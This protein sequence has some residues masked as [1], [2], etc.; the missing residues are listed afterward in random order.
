MDLRGKNDWTNQNLIVRIPV[1]PVMGKDGKEIKGKFLEIQADHSNYN[2]KTVAKGTNKVKEGALPPQR[3]PYLNSKKVAGKDGNTFLS[4]DALYTLPQV[5]KIVAAAGDAHFRTKS[6]TTG[7]EY[8]VYG[9]NAN[10]V[11]VH[12]GDK[13]RQQVLINTKEPITKTTNEKFDENILKRQYNVT[14]AVADLAKSK[15]PEDSTKAPEASTKAPEVAAEVQIPD[16]ESD[17]GD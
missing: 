8:D 12:K 3:N 10:L 17:F 5:E 14:K 11:L 15:A 13:E 2:P 6:P 4:N 16:V 7:K 9:V 1:D